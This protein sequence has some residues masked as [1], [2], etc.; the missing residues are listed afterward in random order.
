MDGIEAVPRPWAKEYASLEREEAAK[1]SGEGTGEENDEAAEVDGMT[2]EDL[3]FSHLKQAAKARDNVSLIDPFQYSGRKAQA[4]YFLELTNPEIV[5]L[6]LFST[7]SLSV[8]IVSTN[9]SR[10]VT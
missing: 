8:K 3:I 5:P 9:Q 4:G 2:E 10:S 1:S 6:A 7:V